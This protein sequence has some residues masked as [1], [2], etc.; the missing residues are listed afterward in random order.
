VA[1][2]AYPCRILS[3]RDQPSFSCRVWFGWVLCGLVLDRVDATIM[4][5]THAVM[6]ADTAMHMRDEFSAH[7]S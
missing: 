1:S 7:A 3:D 6:H 5:L 2:N 4:H